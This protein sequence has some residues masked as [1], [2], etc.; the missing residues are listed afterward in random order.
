M[1]TKKNNSSV[2]MDEVLEEAIHTTGG[3]KGASTI[4]IKKY[5]AAHYPH[6]DIENRTYLL[7]Q[8]VKRGVSKGQLKQMSGTGFTGFY[9]LVGGKERPS[10]TKRQKDAAKTA[11]KK[12]VSSHRAIVKKKVSK[13]PPAF[14]R[15]PDEKPTTIDL[16]EEALAMVGGSKGASAQAIRKYLAEN[17]PDTKKHLVKQA[18]ERAQKK[19]LVKQLS[20]TGAS[21]TFKWIGPKRKPKEREEAPKS[22]KK[23]PAA[24]KM[25]IPEP[26]KMEIIIRDAM[27]EHCEPKEASPQAIKKY[28]S[29]HYPHLEIETRSYLLKRALQKGVEN[30]QL[31]QLSGKGMSGTFRLVESYKPK[32]PMETMIGVAIKA[33]NEPKEA[34]VGMI[35]KYIREHY[36]T[37]DIENHMF[38]LKRGLEKGVKNGE[39]EQITGKGASGTYQLTEPFIPSPEDLELIEYVPPMEVLLRSAFHRGSKT[40]VQKPTEVKV[41]KARGRPKSRPVKK[42]KPKAAGRGR[43]KGKKGRG[44]PKKAGK[45]EAKEAEDAP[46]E[47]AS[48]EEE[49]TAKESE[50]EPKESASSEEDA[51]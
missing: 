30:G 1:P 17:Y 47:S 6:L 48:S 9:K 50:E 36:P 15:D 32:K 26:P 42:P 35:K 8:A 10:L 12:V 16:V 18:L 38:K 23:T 45:T 20:G 4:A 19:D 21:G 28:L 29:E 44:R 3:P 41:K 25:A 24:K 49:E 37:L 40:K 46:K 5:I 7:K 51:Q 43:G 11:A 31:L 39:L 22:P 13:P 33:A 14:Y 27:V 34:S 2:R